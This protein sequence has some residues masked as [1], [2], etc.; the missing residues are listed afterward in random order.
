ETWVF[1]ARE[2]AARAAALAERNARVVCLPGVDGR[3]DL[4]A[5]M[6]WLGE[7]GINEV[8]AEAGAVLTGALWQAGC[9]DELLV[10][11]APM[12]IGDARGMARLPALG[13]LDDARRFVFDET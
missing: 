10:Y 5:V 12:L 8:H 11:L 2:D 3:V 13:G 6:R 4:P 7:H 1:S 9:V